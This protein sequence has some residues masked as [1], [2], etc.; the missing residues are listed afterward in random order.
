MG[1][2]QVEHLSK[3]QTSKNWKKER[4]KSYD[5]TYTSFTHIYRKHKLYV[6]YLHKELGEKHEAKSIITKLL[7]QVKG[8]KSK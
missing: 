4:L 5:S 7:C 6:S 8:K 2:M 1:D 3:E